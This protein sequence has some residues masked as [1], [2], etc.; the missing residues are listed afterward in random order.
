M[1]IGTL[2]GSVFFGKL[3]EGRIIKAE[4][5]LSR[6]SQWKGVFLLKHEPSPSSDKMMIG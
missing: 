1:L 2:R 6:D 5:K 4:N 3:I